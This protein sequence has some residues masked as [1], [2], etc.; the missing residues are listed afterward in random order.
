MRTIVLGQLFSPGAF[1]QYLLIAVVSALLCTIPSF[2]E[3]WRPAL[4]TV[5]V[6]GGA[7]GGTG[8]LVM[9]TFAYTADLVTEKSRGIAFAAM[10][11]AFGLGG[12]IGYLGGGYIAK[13]LGAA[14]V[15]WVVAGVL[16]AVLVYMAVLPESLAHNLRSDSVPLYKANSLYCLHVL[17]GRPSATR[18]RKQWAL[19]LLSMAFALSF[20]SEMGVSSISTLFLSAKPLRWDDVQVGTFNAVNAA[21]RSASAVL[22][23]PLLAR[24]VSWERHELW[25][26]GISL[27]L[28]GSSIELVGALSSELAILVA[29][30]A[31]GLAIPVAFGFMRCAFSRSVDAMHQGQMLAALA[32]LESLCIVLGPL[33]FNTLY[34]AT[35]GRDGSLRSL[36]WYIIGGLNV[37]AAAL[38]MPVPPIRPGAT[39]WPRGRETD[40]LLSVQ[41]EETT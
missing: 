27:L 3:F 5:W 40:R 12:M 25:V 1:V 37:V 26:A 14:D 34:E 30:A 38:L 41:H 29:V 24:V 33:V 4:V 18:P 36:C 10:E 23:L 21:A 17:F 31:S 35:T 39:E 9:N 8:M 16:V 2:A 13:I 11:S 20:L 22:A 32:F 6:L 15:F 19:L 7:M 28:Y